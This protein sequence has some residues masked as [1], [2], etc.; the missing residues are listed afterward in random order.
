MFLFGRNTLLNILLVSCVVALGSTFSLA[1]IEAEKAPGSNSTN[2]LSPSMVDPVPVSSAEGMFEITMP[3]G[4][5]MVH[6][7]SPK[8][9][10]DGLTSFVYVYCDRYEEKGEGFSVSTWLGS[11]DPNGSNLGF[12]DLKFRAEEN[13]GKFGVEVIKQVPLEVALPSGQKMIG[14][15]L[16]TQ[17]PDEV[18]QVWLR[19]WVVSGR[20]YLLM[21]W[22]SSGD[23]LQQT[24]VKEFFDSFQPM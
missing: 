15:D 9:G 18:G 3:P 2:G 10:E 24:G 12:S 23:L 6:K 8:I 20:V 5:Y 7:V 22:R 4:C 14:V 21:A 16:Y 13:M 1:Q 17:T 19:G 11:D